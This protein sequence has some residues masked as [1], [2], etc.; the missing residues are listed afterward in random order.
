M[1]LTFDGL[2]SMYVPSKA[3]VFPG[4]VFED[5]L[6][7]CIIKHAVDNL[8]LKVFE[9]IRPRLGSW[10]A[11]GTENFFR[12]VVGIATF[13]AS[14]T[15]S[16]P[17]GSMPLHIDIPSPLSLRAMRIFQRSS[18]DNWTSN[19]ESIWGG[20]FSLATVPTAPIADGLAEVARLWARAVAATKHDRFQ[21]RENVQNTTN[22]PQSSVYTRCSE[23]LIDVG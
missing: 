11:G 10:S 15:F 5:L 3:F 8:I 6:G 18:S 7:A 21:W 2:S 13:G 1:W 14:I 9:L 23:T 20:H 22:A 17:M 16:V 19:L 4:I 12:T